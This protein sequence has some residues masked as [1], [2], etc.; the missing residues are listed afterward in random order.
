MAVHVTVDFEWN[1]QDPI[2]CGC[3]KSITRLDFPQGETV[4]CL[5]RQNLVI[6]VKL[7]G[8]VDNTVS[9]KKIVGENLYISGVH[10]QK[11]E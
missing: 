7:K 6:L 1:L 8:T 9:F 11:Q 10:L 4:N 2:L 3:I 5:P